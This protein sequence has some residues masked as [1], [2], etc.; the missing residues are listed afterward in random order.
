MTY[1][2]FKECLLAVVIICTILGVWEW[3]EDKLGWG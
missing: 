1:H 3:V 2:E